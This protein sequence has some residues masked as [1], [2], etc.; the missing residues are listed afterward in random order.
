MLKRQVGI[1][2]MEKEDVYRI[3]IDSYIYRI[4]HRLL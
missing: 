3:I 4:R 1:T 2:Y